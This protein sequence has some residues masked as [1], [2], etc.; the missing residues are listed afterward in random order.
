MLEGKAGTRGLYA[1]TPDEP[2]TL[3]LLAAAEAV[4]AGGGRW[5]QY[6]DKISLPGLRRERAEALEALCRRHGAALI[7]NDDVELAQVVGAA[8][9]HL[10]RDDGDLAAARAQ[11]GR[12]AII[13]ASCYADFACARRT[14]AAGASYVAFGAAYPSSTKPAAVRAPIELF[15]R[16]RNEI[17][18]PVC[19]I[20]GITLANAAP[21]I[22]AGADL[23]AV[24]TDLFSAPDIAAR[25]A[26]Y[27]HLFE[28]YQHDR[29]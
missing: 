4:L 3:R 26:A 12:D 6:R 28:E 21:L 15:A 22:S 23:I 18:V 1:I 27:Q 7:V 5:L 2:D 19:A 16:A 8:G 11:L 24:I 20:G 17:D 29:S 10:G 13:G 14:A 25:A 9:V